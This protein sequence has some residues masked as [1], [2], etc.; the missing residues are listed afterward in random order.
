L[1]LEH[2][3]AT[4]TQPALVHR[5]RSGSLT[6][7]SASARV[8]KYRR[9]RFLSPCFPRSTTHFTRPC[10]G[11][12]CRCLAI[13][14]ALAHRIHTQFE[15]LICDLHRLFLDANA[16]S[17]TVNDFSAA[18]QRRAYIEL[19]GPSGYTGSGG[20]GRILTTVSERNAN[21]SASSRE[22]RYSFVLASICCGVLGI[23]IP[24]FMHLPFVVLS[25]ATSAAR[26]EKRARSSPAIV[27]NTPDCAD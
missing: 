4:R 2:Q 8:S 1:R 13:V 16:I 12:A 15:V 22:S 18:S 24:A 20:D 14:R 7:P 23:H 9:A 21:H 6:K 27:A 19:R 17:S 26:L 3:R 5:G 10:R 11:C 25:P